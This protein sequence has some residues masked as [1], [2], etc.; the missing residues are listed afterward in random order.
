MI[1]SGVRYKNIN[2]TIYQWNV[3]KNPICQWRGCFTIRVVSFWT[4]LLNIYGLVC[5][6]TSRI[7]VPIN[8]NILPTVISYILCNLQYSKTTQHSKKIILMTIVTQG[9]GFLFSKRLHGHRSIQNIPSQF[10]RRQVER[11]TKTSLWRNNMDRHVPSCNVQFTQ[12]NIILNDQDVIIQAI[13]FR[14][15]LTSSYITTNINQQ[16]KGNNTSTWILNARH[17]RL[18]LYPILIQISIPIT[19]LLKS[20]CQI[21]FDMK[22]TFLCIALCKFLTPGSRL[23]LNEY[24]ENRI[25]N[26]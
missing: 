9:W 23:P 6:V 24:A 26:F 2:L 25:I 14:A 7:N 13:T 10:V 3:K 22:F 12:F 1:Q 17:N 19:R 20:L 18:G 16:F 21:H 15:T 5:V 11:F 4:I 8:W